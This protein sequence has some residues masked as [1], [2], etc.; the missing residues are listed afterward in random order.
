LRCLQTTAE[1]CKILGVKRIDVNYLVGE[2][3]KDKFFETNPIDD[4]LIRNRDSEYMQEKYLG[5]VQYNDKTLKINFN[6]IDFRKL[7]NEQK[8]CVSLQ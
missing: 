4:L 3:M 7:S 8:D 1:T 5:G 6:K 2:W